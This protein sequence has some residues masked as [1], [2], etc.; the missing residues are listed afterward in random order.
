MIVS[1]ETA[2]GTVS[3]DTDAGT[4]TVTSGAVTSSPEPVP[5]IWQAW[6]DAAVVEASAEANRAAL[7]ATV[8]DGIESLRAARDQAQ[9][10]AD[11]EFTAAP[12]YSPAQLQAFVDASRTLS[13]AAVA[14]LDASIRFARLLG[15][16]L[17]GLD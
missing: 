10:I 11:T 16:R 3:V 15:D 8:A 7:K 6:V 4:F 12:I 5:A 14:A 1:R 13:A 9:A 2:E 17:E